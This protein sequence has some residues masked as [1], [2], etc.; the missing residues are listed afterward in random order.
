MNIIKSAILSGIVALS[1]PAVPHVGEIVIPTGE[2]VNSVCEVAYHVYERCE[3]ENNVT[4]SWDVDSHE[5]KHFS[6]EHYVFG[7]R[8]DAFIISKNHH[9][10]GQYEWYTWDIEGWQNVDENWFEFRMG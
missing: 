1:I 5:S 4:I 8:E 3:L 9:E 2:T 10:Q 7:D 6:I